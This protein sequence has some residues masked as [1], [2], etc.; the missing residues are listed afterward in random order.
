[1]LRLILLRWLLIL[2]AAI[3]KPLTIL[4]YKLH[5]TTTSWT[6]T[7]NL[8]FSYQIYLASFIYLYRGQITRDFRIIC[9]T[10]I[11]LSPSLS[12]GVIMRISGRF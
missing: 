6:C 2:P 4:L 3:T 11:C 1:L 5:L 10:F 7:H 8:T 12:K 9:F